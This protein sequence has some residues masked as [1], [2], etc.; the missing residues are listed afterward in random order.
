[1]S[2]ATAFGAVR[3][4]FDVT[5]VLTGLLFLALALMIA[6]STVVRK[7]GHPIAATDELASDM[8]L[9]GVFL[10][11]GGTYLHGG[12]V[13]V[14]T[15]VERLAPRA[16]HLCQAAAD[17][18]AALFALVFLRAAWQDFTQALQAHETS[19]VLVGFPE[20]PIKLSMVVGSA[21]LLVAALVSMPRR[22]AGSAR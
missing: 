12:H 15:V 18:V 7:A 13:N 16:R 2:P 21:L 22:F 14:D 1:M 6:W 17:I 8:L 4:A 20:W 9:W 19:L 5:L 10:A 11:A 3:R